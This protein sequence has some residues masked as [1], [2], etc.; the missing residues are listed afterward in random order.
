MK[1]HP[2]ITVT[3]T[4]H[5]E[6]QLAVPSLDSMRDLVLAAS[7]SGLVVEARAMLDRADD[8]TRRLVA[9]RGAWLDDVQE[10]AYGDLGLSRNAGVSAARGNYLAFLD[11]DDLWG[12]EWLR[13]A[14]ASAQASSVEAIWHPEFLY[15]FTEGDFDRHSINRIPHPHARSFHMRQVSSEEAGFVRDALFLNNIWTANVFVPRAIYDEHPYVAVD[16]NKGFGIEDWSWHID[17]V[18]SNIPHLIVPNTVHMIRVKDGS[19]L[20]QQNASE[21]LLPAIPL[22]ALKQ[23]G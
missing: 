16:R 1:H 22:L 11:G 18:W 20:G 23:S 14:F 5:R 3:I 8:E 6:G 21:G 13:L 12:S 15:Y 4:F 10:V 17:T 9:E 7:R 19:L 2:D